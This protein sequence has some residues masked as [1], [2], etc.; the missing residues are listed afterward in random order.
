MIQEIRDAVARIRVT[1]VRIGT[2]IRQEVRTMIAIVALLTT[3]LPWFSSGYFGLSPFL[4]IQL[5]G[6]LG[7]QVGSMLVFL[8][9]AAL[10]LWVMRTRIWEVT[11]ALLAFLGI[12]II[13]LSVNGSGAE[14]GL[15]IE[16][17]IFL[18]ILIDGGEW[19]L[20]TQPSS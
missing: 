10:F 11:A 5:S 20:N 15:I 2:P 16:I 1:A 13:A 9:V 3:L 12:F 18:A 19:M 17:I 6:N 4:G 8:S 14:L 7:M